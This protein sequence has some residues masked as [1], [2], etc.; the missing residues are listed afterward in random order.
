MMNKEYKLNYKN[1]I[2]YITFIDKIK[3]LFIKP[4]YLYNKEF[5]FKIKYKICKGKVYILKEIWG[6]VDDE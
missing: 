5:N 4:M 2:K 3:L 1:A 6:D